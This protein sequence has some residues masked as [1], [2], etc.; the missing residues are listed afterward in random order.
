MAL[1][2]LFKELRSSFGFL[3]FKN[4]IYQYVFGGPIENT[5]ENFWYMFFFNAN[6]PV[7]FWHIFIFTLE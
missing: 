6:N 1:S 7:L 5:I 2:L 3:K 4:Q